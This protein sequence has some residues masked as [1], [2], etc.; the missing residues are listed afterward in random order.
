MLTAQEVHIEINQI[1]Q[2]ITSNA[3]DKFL[4]EEIDWIYNKIRDRFILSCVKP[5]ADGSGGFQVDEAFAD[6]I[7]T[8]IERNK[9]LITYKEKTDEAYCLLPSNYNYL[10]ND[11]SYVL[12]DCSTSFTS[13]TTTSTI[14]IGKLLFSDSTE[15][16]SNCYSTF[17]IV[18]NN[19]I[20]FNISNYNI[21]DGLN[22]KNEKFV[23][24]HLVLE[25]LTKLGFNIYWERYNNIYERDTFLIVSST[26]SSG[27][28]TIDT[29]VNNIRNVTSSVQVF[30]STFEKEVPNRLTKTTALPDVRF[31]NIFHKTIPNSPISSLA[32]N[33]IYVFYSE[34]RFIV[35]KL[36][37][38]HVRKPTKLSLILN[39]SCELPEIGVLKVCELAGEYIKNIIES[40][41]YQMKLQDNMVRME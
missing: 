5:K 35:N 3:Y 28:I 21:S 22:S 16:N 24:I 18:L 31:N 39:N 23:L 4:P 20:V 11:R 19:Q 10:L 9:E 33:K 34:K 12:S 25:V 41:A 32:N 36:I 7:Q 38:D 17:N 26:I 1:I 2:K 29:V 6:Y 13:N 27:F 40:P 14:Y 30:N 8:I 37:I 15:T